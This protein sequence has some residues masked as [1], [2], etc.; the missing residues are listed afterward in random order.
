MGSVSD[1]KFQFTVYR[2]IHKTLFNADGDV[3]GK[4]EHKVQPNRLLFFNCK[5]VTFCFSC[6]QLAAFI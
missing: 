2:A 6:I 4:D 5:K 1:K 3:D